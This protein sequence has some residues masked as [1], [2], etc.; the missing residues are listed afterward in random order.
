MAALEKIDSRAS[1]DQQ[2]KL[3]RLFDG[4]KI[5]QRLFDAIIENV[6]IPAMQTAYKASLRVGDNYT[7]VHAVD[8]NA[9]G[10]GLG[11]GRLL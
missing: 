10:L 7:D 5:G 8:A 2:Q 6:K 11:R 3:G 1:L 4:G 9:D